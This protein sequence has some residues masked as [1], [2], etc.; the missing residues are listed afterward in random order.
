MIY[1]FK[2]LAF[3]ADF[4]TR[5]FTKCITSCGNNFVSQ[6]ILNSLF[7]LYKFSQSSSSIEK[8]TKVSAATRD[9]QDLPDKR[10][11]APIIS[12]AENF[13]NVVILLFILSISLAL[14]SLII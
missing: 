12:P 11:A 5:F 13:P 9:S 3:L 1:S 8:A 7:L 6:N 2:L 14:P 10:L 4:S